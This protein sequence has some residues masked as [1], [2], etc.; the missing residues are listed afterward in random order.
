MEALKGLFKDTE[1]PAE[2][3]RRLSALLDGWPDVHSAVRRLRQQ[4]G[5]QLYNDGNGLTYGAIGDLI[6]V[7]ESRARH[8]VKG[9]TNPSRQKRKA[10]EEEARRA[11]RE[12]RGM[13]DGS[14]E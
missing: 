1:D 11:E 6:S 13:G 3:F 14:A 4:V 7:T 9:I 10:E 5:E 8:I 12:R 2:R